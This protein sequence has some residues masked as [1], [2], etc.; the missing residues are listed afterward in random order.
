MIELKPEELAIAKDI[1]AKFG[2]NAVF[3]RVPTMGLLAFAPPEQPAEV[4]WKF[5][6]D[7]AN[8]ELDRS[9][10]FGA[11]A[12]ACLVYPGRDEVATLFR[13][14]PAFA[15][16]CGISCQKMLGDAAQDEDPEINELT[17]PDEA[18]KLA[19]LREQHGEVGWLMTKQLGLVV[20][21]PTES[22][23]AYRQFFNAI[24]V[25]RSDRGA[26]EQFCLDVVVHPQNV[27]ETLKQWPGL[28]GP[29]ASRGDGICGGDYE[30]LGNI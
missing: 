8:Q 24:S 20:V 27:A 21:R 3:F 10:T 28:T 26:I 30:Q 7:L 19:E 11:L 25:N 16:N 9:G 2:G 6:V 12:L 22:P 29:I 23:A 14:R 18:K 13:A 5:K 4:F 17:H 15:A 1:K